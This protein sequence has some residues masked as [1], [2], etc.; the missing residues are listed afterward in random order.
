MRYNELPTTHIKSKENKGKDLD[1]YS[2]NTDMCLKSPEQH[3]FY[4]NTM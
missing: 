3:T 2:S 1:D 4:T